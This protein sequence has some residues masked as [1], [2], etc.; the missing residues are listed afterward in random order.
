MEGIG[1]AMPIEN[2]MKKPQLFLGCPGILNT[3][4]ITLVILYSVIGFFGFARYGDDVKGSVT[5]NLPDGVMFV[6]YKLLGLI[7][8]LLNNLCN[9]FTVLPKL[10]K[11][12]LPPPFCSPLGWNSTCPLK[13]CGGKLREESQGNTIMSYRSC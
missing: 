4:M 7:C 13:S 5:M 6:F 2:D 1:A 3:T 10:P 11:F 9:I 8:I 12:L